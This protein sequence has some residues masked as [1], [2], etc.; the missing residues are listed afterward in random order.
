MSTGR[1]R[2]VRGTSRQP[3]A[4]IA[5]PSADLY[6]S[7]RMLLEA[8]TGLVQHGWRV[9]FTTPDEGP[10]IERIRAAGAQVQFLP[11]PVVRKRMLH[12]LRLPAFAFEVVRRMPAMVRLIRANAPHVVV[13]NTVTIPFWTIAARLRRTPAVVYVHE[14]EAG[15]PTLART[16]LTAP[17]S[18]ADGIIFNSETSRRVSAPRGLTRR[19]RTR[20]VPNGVAGP[21]A[22]TL[23]REVI[24]GPLRIVYVGRL[25]PRKGVDLVV[26]AV[27][28]LR[29]RGIPA[30]LELVG[31][32]FPGYEW[33]EQQLREQIIRLRLEGT[34]TL[35]GFQ[36]PVWDALARADVSVVPSRQDESFG[37]VLIEALL[38]ARP[39]IA[40]EH[41]GLQEAAMGFEAAT[42]VASDDADALADALA[43]V[44]SRW[45]SIRA[46]AIADQ[47]LANDRHAPTLFHR[48]FA[49]ALAERARRP[50]HR[51]GE[52]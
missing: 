34:V 48:R 19:G 1:R 51:S 33:Y 31:S 9:V 36:S 32:V 45:E 12:P 24:E 21:E 35:R 23:P 26:D 42:I 43:T 3:T 46:A 2:D 11:A 25:S 40:T 13:S 22:F 39:V 47:V 15:L 6:G 49:R 37:N 28:T 10:L 4:L 14:A 5:N 18:W 50:R 20:V 38:S 27:A 8:V 52:N 7:D 41:S 29:D 44:R 17:L 16:V 30:E